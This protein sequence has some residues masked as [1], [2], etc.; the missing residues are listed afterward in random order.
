MKTCAKC[1]E[2]K[3][4]SEFHKNR[5]QKD[6]LARDCKVCACARRKAYVD[7]RPGLQAANGLAY[8]HGLTI[9]Q[10]EAILQYQ[11]GGCAICETKTPGGKYNQF[12]VDH[13]HSCCPG[14]RSCGKCI[15]GLLC[16]NCNTAL[17]LFGDDIT[18]LMSAVNYL[19]SS[20]TPSH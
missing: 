19:L 15:R 3:S 10:R 16:H 8:R 11:N 1:K 12:H 5:S 17:G 6:G 7:A 18:G 9:E 20:R 14:S 2:P 13:D 4:T